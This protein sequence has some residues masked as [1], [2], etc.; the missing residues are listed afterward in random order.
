MFNYS[1][2]METMTSQDFK[3]LGYLKINY[4]SLYY[5]CC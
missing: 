4:Y 1:I 2:A 5:C 3:A